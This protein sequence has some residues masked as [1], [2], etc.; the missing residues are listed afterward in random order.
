MVPAGWTVAVDCPLPEAARL[1]RARD[2]RE[3]FVVDDATLRGVLSDVDIVVLAIASERSPADLV[4]ADCLGASVVRLQSGQPIL[5]ALAH[6]QRHGLDRAPVVDGDELVGAAWITDLEQAH[7]LDQR[8]E[9]QPVTLVQ[10]PDLLMTL[11]VD[12]ASSCLTVAGE[13]D[14]GTAPSFIDALDTALADGVDH[15]TVDLEHLTFADSSAVHALLRL[16]ATAHG[17]GTRLQLVNVAG[18]VDRTLTLTGTHELFDIA[19]C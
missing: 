14:F 15:L 8:V 10:T 16:R 11:H 18:S 4:V 19:P 6:L 3:V 13:L 12:G 7:R 9:R 1:M 5:D 17:R 2:V